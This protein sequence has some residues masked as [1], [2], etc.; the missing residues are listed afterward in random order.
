[1]RG[2]DWRAVTVGEAFEQAVMWV[3]IILGPVLAAGNV[4]LM[5]V[6]AAHGRIFLAA[7]TAGGAYLSGSAARSA[8]R[9]RRR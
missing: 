3:A 4:I 1:M 7:F 2:T 9:A 8:N 6:N 5:L